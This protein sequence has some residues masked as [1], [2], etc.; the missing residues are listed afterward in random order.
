MAQREK[1]KYIY[2]QQNVNT[3]DEQKRSASLTMSDVSIK[4]GASPVD[5][6]IVLGAL[7][8]YEETSPE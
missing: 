5:L 3:T 2:P 8:L 1:N 7:G 6:L 4:L